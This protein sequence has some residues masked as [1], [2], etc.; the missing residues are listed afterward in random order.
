MQSRHLILTVMGFLLGVKGPEKSFYEVCFVVSFV[1][2]SEE[3]VKCACLVFAARNGARDFF[4]QFF[5]LA[6]M[7][8][9][10]Y[11]FS[12]RISRS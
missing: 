4:R 9:W 1:E 6:C 7:H 8:A 11:P 2:V 12:A 5:C 10:V 3:A